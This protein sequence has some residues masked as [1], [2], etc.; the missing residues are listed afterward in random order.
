MKDEANVMKHEFP[1]DELLETE[2]FVEVLD[3]NKNRDDTMI[4]AGRRVF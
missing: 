2:I 4:G 1:L 3:K